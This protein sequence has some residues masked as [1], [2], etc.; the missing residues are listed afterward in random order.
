MQLDL[1]IDPLPL[2]NPNKNPMAPDCFRDYEQY[3][4]WLGLARLA[5]QEC[6]ICEDCTKGYKEKM[7]AERR[8]HEKWHSVQILMK[9][10][11]APAA[12]KQKVE[13]QKIVICKVKEIQIDP[14]S[15]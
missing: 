15:W 4:E 13:K 5:K 14:L 3:S 2:M 7:I 6:T 12:V 8:C 1:F 9:K 10:K 11:V